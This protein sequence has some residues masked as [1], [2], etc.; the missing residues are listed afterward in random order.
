MRRVLLL[1]LVAGCADVTG[2]EE[3]PDPE[4]PSSVA[5]PVFN[6]GNIIVPFPCELDWYEV[7]PPLC[8]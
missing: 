5:V 7:I 8:Q 1:L 3:S 4:P 2:P 6:P